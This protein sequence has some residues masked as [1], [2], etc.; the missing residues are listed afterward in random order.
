MSQPF[1]STPTPQLVLFDLDGTLVD[2]LPGLTMAT[3]QMLL[4]LGRAPAGIAAVCQWV[5]NGAAT[6]VRRALSNSI[7]V[8]KSL[9]PQ[10]V[11]EALKVFMHA[12]RESI[13]EGTVL[14]PGVRG[15]LDELKLRKVPM[16]IVTN[17]PE[18]FV[19][20]IINSLELHGYFQLVVG[21]DTLATKK[22]DPEPLLHAAK[23]FS[24]PP[25][26]VLMVGDSRHD[27]RAAR[28][29]GMPVACVTYGYNHGESIAESSPDWVVD[30]FMELL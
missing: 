11:N 21:G 6:L 18:G 3:D 1:S 7:E 19:P 23:S 26:R 28:N 14:Y 2:S 27:V 12:Y 13:A 5:G 15:F 17:K 29:A 20:D 8:D 25:A 30:S 9:D 10:L 24:V 22:P 4:S 16:A